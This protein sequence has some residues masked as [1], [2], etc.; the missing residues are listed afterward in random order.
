VASAVSAWLGHVQLE[1]GLGEAAL[2]VAAVTINVLL[3]AMVRLAILDWRAEKQSRR[4]WTA[5]AGIAELATPPPLEALEGSSGDPYAPAPHNPA[6]WHMLRAHRHV[7][8]VSHT[9]PVPIIPSADAGAEPLRSAPQSA[10]LS[11]AALLPASHPADNG[12]ADAA[13][14]HRDAAERDEI[15]KEVGQ[16]F[17]S[18]A[19]APAATKVLRQLGPRV[20]TQVRRVA[21]AAWP[22]SYRAVRV[23]GVPVEIVSD[24]VVGQGD[25][26]PSDGGNSPRTRFNGGTAQEGHRWHC[27]LGHASTKRTTPGLGQQ[28]GP[29]NRSRGTT[30]DRR[31]GRGLARQAAREDDAAENA[32]ERSRSPQDTPA[33]ELPSGDAKDDV[34]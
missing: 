13:S 16:S 7:V 33:E 2:A 8:P 5:I 26:G 29:D 1:P 27:W 18:A 30:Q 31:S 34:S 20:A 28:P 32:K 6:L 21:N 19:P 25:K 17:H 23:L 12:G 3:V 11:P 15:L 24:I 9:E 10:P 4:A 22:G 14:A